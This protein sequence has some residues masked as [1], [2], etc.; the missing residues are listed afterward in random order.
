MLLI[1]DIVMHCRVVYVYGIMIKVF[2]SGVQSLSF[3]SEN[4]NYSKYVLSRGSS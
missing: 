3:K 4:A 2:K 1:G